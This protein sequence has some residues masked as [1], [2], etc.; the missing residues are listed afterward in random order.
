MYILITGGFD[1][2]HSGHLSMFNHAKSIYNCNLVIGLNSDNYLLS[3]KNTFLLPYSERA[4]ILRSIKYVDFVLDRWDDEDGSSCSAITQFYN[5]FGPD[6]LAFANGGDRDYTTANINE[7]N[8]CTKLQ[9]A[10]LYGLG[11]KKVISSTKLL[12]NSIANLSLSSIST[13]KKNKK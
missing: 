13:I 2:L 9:I 5:R 8:L 11:G 6:N 7:V 10:Q 12:H 4:D 1:P 3:K